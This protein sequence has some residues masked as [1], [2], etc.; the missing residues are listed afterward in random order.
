MGGESGRL[1]AIGWAL[2]FNVMRGRT[3]VES[4]GRIRCRD[5]TRNCMHRVG[6]P[7]AWRTG[8][9]SLSVTSPARGDCAPTRW[10]CRRI[11]AP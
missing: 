5:H 9:T 4:S 7:G 10:I 8:A 2:R 6:V 3:G 1:P 11:S